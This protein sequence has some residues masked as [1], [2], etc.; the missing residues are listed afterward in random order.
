MDILIKS[1]NRPYYLDRC[2]FSINKHVIIGNG[3]I[4][5]LDDGTPQI[6][7]DRI[8]EK[9]PNIII[10]K[11]EFYEKKVQFTTKGKRP[12]KYSI[13]VNLWVDSAKRASENFILIED[14]TWFI[15]IVN[16][17]EVD[18]EITQNN[19]ALTKLYWIGNSI[20]NQN[21]KETSLKNIVL[22]KPKLLT[23]I[24]ALYYFI[25]YKFDRFKIRKILR[26]FKIN[27][28][29]KQL[30]YRT[31]YAVAGMIFNKNYFVKLWD[32][33]QNNVDE[34]LQ[35]YNAVKVFKEQKHTIKFARYHH[36][37]LRTGFMSAATNQHKESY[38]GNVDMF[39]FNK[40][41]NESWL[42]NQLDVISSLPNDIN[43]EEIIRI[44]DS[45]KQKTILSKDWLSW[46]GSFKSYYLEMGC[47]ID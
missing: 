37:I 44:L 38:V 35:I 39:A 6:Y 4:I 26:F 9:Y 20:I 24:P 19:V 30:A 15:D 46:V 45:D 8:T 34:G 5:V 42:H 33:H 18:A 13:P 22:L 11:S 28:N 32:N 25:F 41:M 43:A 16:L 10:K 47:K 29:E 21:K 12:E 7:L 3:K 40:L 17:G 14:D 36:E 1:Y 2:L 27:T 31:I 23:T